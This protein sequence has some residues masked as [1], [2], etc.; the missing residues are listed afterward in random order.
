MREAIA[1]VTEALRT[2]DK[3]EP[4]SSEVKATDEFL[5]PLFKKFFQK[6]ALPLQL[7][8]SDYYVL[9]SLVP[10]EKLD[11][12]IAEKLDAL[13]AVAEKAKLMTD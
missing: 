7:R 4:W 2:L 3:P 13:V 1:E 10:R 12:E 8:K 11:G 9:A 6:L 5:D